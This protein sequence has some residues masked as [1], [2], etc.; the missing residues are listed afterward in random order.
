MPSMY[1]ANVTNQNQ[2][3][4]YR[5]DYDKAGNLEELR[6]FRPASQQLFEPGRQGVLGARD[7][8]MTQIEDVVSQL[9][10]YGLL[11]VKD[12]STLSDAVPRVPY[13]FNVGQPVPAD[14]MRRV[15]D[16]NKRVMSH[17]GALR[18]QKA[19]VATNEVVQ[20]AV[21]QQFIEQGIPAQP[22]DSTEVVFEQVD[23][24]EDQAAAGPRIEEGFEIVP[25]G[26]VG[27]KSG[28]PAAEI[29]R[30]RGRPRKNG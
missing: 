28:K 1:L 2:L 21:E 15:Q 29:K 27:R 11:G 8:H 17:E 26:K 13:V 5:L 18:R 6:R 4:H 20:H 10:P 19:A 24:T 22:A 7:M 30:G 14:V 9:T 3:V 12:V 23:Q 16:H 25:E